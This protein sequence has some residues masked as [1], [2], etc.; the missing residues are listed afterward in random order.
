M[1]KIEPAAAIGD[2][3]AVKTSDETSSITGIVSGEDIDV[4]YYTFVDL[5]LSSHVE[6]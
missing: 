5:M 2:L 6:H 4:Q 3:T 1:W